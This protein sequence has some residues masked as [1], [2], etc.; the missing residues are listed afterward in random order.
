MCQPTY[1]KKHCIIR[2]YYPKKK[3]A[4]YIEWNKHLILQWKF[5]YYM[6]T[7]IFNKNIYLREST[8]ST[9]KHKISIIPLRAI[10]WFDFSHIPRQQAWIIF[11]E[12][13]DGIKEAL[14]ITKMNN[15]LYIHDNKQ[16]NYFIH[17]V[18][19][20]QTEIYQIKLS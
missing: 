5:I 2:L 11:L 17:M 16:I 13:L 12:N 1:N 19:S 14:L 18:N 15:I 9:K 3:R 10:K 4:L 20:L 7:I 8:L 6:I